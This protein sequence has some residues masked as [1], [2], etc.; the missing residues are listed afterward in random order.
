MGYLRLRLYGSIIPLWRGTSVRGHL[1]IL[2]FHVSLGRV[3]TLIVEYALNL[4]Y[5]YML[6]DPLT[7]SKP[8]GVSVFRAMLG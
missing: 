7:L 1:M 5:V 4:Q 2:V 6:G 8:E 3:V